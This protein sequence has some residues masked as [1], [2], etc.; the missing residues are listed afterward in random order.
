MSAAQPAIGEA[1]HYRSHGSADGTYKA[2][3]RTAHVTE[4]GQWVTV[5]TEHADIAA[6]TPDVLEKNGGRPI[7]RLEQWW[8]T[9]AIALSVH[10]PTGLFFHTAC[11][12]DPGNRDGGSWHWPTECGTQPQ[13][14]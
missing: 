5:A 10:N 8:F 2:T 6:V 1:V 7:R 11:R 4:A 3:C 13:V 9:D 12:H 14:T